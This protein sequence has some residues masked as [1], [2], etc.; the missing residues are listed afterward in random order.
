MFKILRNGSLLLIASLSMSVHASS[1]QRNYEIWEPEQAPNRGGDFDIIT[2]GACPLTK[3]GKNGLTP[4]AMATWGPICLGEWIQNAFKITEKT[5][6]HEGI[7]G[8]G[9]VTTFAELYLDFNHK[10]SRTIV[11]P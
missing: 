4:L 3:I 2:M 9:G 1:P 11:A 10:M 7:Y 8:G 5:L 6:H